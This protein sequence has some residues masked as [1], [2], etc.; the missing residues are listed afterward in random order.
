MRDVASSYSDDFSQQHHHAVRICVFQQLYFVEVRRHIVF[1]LI[2]NC[3]RCQHQNETA[4]PLGQA[5]DFNISISHLSTNN[6]RILSQI[7]HH[8]SYAM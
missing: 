3:L 2:N 1:E 5:F 6:R 7:I 4:I 8:L